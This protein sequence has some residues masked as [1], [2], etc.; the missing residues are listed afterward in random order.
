MKIRTWD[1]VQI[2]S[3]KKADRGVVSEVIKAFP[4]TNKVLV[5]DV[6]M[7]TKHVKKQWVNPGQKITMEKPIHVSNVMLICPFTEKPT[8]V[9]FV[10]IEQKGKVKKFRF[11]KK[12]LA[13]KWWESKDF[14][15]K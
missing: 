9:W 10:K 2:M 11:S 1:T 4:D 14:I 3:G 5:K 7:A 6:N 12:A 15:I 8:R 13:E